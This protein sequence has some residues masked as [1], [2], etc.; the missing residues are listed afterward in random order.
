[1]FAQQ[2]IKQFEYNIDKNT[3][4]KHQIKENT[5]SLIYKNI[6]SQQIPN[7]VNNIP[8]SNKRYIYS[9]GVSNPDSDSVQAVSTAINRAELM[10]S[11]L[12]KSTVQQLCSY[13]LNEYDISSNILYENYV[14]IVSNTKFKK[15]T[16]EKTYTNRYNETIV[17]VKFNTRSAI[18]TDTKNILSIYKNEFNSTT[19]E[20][21]ETVYELS[22]EVKDA[23]SLIYQLTT[24]GEHIELLTKIDD[25]T[26]KI[27]IY[28]LSYLTTNDTIVNNKTLSY[29]LWNEVLKTTV[30]VI[31]KEARSKP[32]TLQNL[33]DKYQNKSY[34]KLTNGIA[35]N[36]IS[37]R[38]KEININNNGVE[39][40]IYKP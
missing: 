14:Q 40:S 25:K 36:T 2:N 8:P 17:L 15:Y 27:P 3:N 38:L 9:I 13:F 26:T 18:S 39:I 21:L 37:I 31:V 24:L 22:K 7:W 10:A 30:D 16:I 33:G 23:S 20:Q 11:I 12:Y 5:Y 35:Q 4:T 34:Q 1:M 28:N 32:G 19:S 29:G 6:K